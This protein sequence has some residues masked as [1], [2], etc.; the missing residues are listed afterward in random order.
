[1]SYRS[2]CTIFLALLYFALLTL[3]GV[4]LTQMWNGP[5]FITSL[6]AAEAQVGM[7]ELVVPLPPGCINGTPT[8]GEI[9]VCCI[10]G[11]V[12]LNGEPVS[13]AEVTIQNSTGSLQVSTQRHSGDEERPYYRAPLNTA[14]ISATKGSIITVSVQ[15]A[16]LRKSVQHVVQ[17]GSQQVDLVLNP[18]GLSIGAGLIE[19]PTPGRF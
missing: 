11:L 8:G 14:P 1:M 5:L 15:Y 18:T 16:G 9:P 13:G 7:T 10:K 12:I 6:Y 3:S 2:L 19:Q 4:T 17:D